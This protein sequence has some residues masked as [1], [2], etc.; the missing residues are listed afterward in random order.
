MRAW[1]NVMMEMRLNAMHSCIGWHED[2]YD[3]L[4]LMSLAAWSGWRSGTGVG[5][6]LYNP[7]GAVCS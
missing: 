4:L 5:H 7:F 1:Q 2:P 6:F 3:T